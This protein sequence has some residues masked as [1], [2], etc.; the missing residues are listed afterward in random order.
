METLRGPFEWF[1]RTRYCLKLLDVEASES[2]GYWT[3]KKQC[4]SSCRSPLHGTLFNEGPV[5]HTIYY[6][7]AEARDARGRFL[8]PYQTWYAARAGLL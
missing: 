1:L 6:Q 3:I 8:S 2:R 5:S 7:D 4:D